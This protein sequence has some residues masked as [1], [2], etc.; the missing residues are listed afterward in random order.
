ML[1]TGLVVW[2]LNRSWPFGSAGE[3]WATGFWWLALTILFEFGF[4]HFVAGHS[5]QTLLA[6]YNIFA[7]RLWLFFL[8]WITVMPWLVHRL[9]TTD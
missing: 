6:D 9:A 1:A 2:F 8:G 7:G 3:A 5:W 4:G